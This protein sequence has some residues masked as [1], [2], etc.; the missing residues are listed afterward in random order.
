MTR[1]IRHAADFLRRI[2]LHILMNTRIL[3]LA[4]LAALVS[5]PAALH[6][7]IGWS[8]SRN[9]DTLVPGVTET[10]SDR[11]VSGSF[12]WA[13]GTDADFGDSHKLTYFRFSLTETT[14]VSI[15]AS[16]VYLAGQTGAA[17]TLLPAFS[18]YSTSASN[19]GAMPTSTHDTSTASIEYLAGLG[20]TAK[21]GAFN[22]LGDWRIYNDG[23]LYGQFDYVGSIADGSFDALSGITGDGV[24]DGFVTLTFTDLVAGEYFIV[25]GGANY[26][27][28]LTETAT[29]G[30]TGTSFPT[31]GIEVSVTAIPEPSAFAA[32]AGL[33]ALG[34]AALRRRR[35]A[36]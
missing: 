9:F 19:N 18:L 6:A 3:S 14:T 30:S 32:L 11:T 22:A 36:A 16:S 33:G 17:D 21:E 28:Q 34:L 27:A 23:G 15:S 10:S 31:Y 24:A 29:Y 26:G 2:I 8:G 25:V 4:A 13:D 7:H 5:A 35:R 1:V 20:G 12:G